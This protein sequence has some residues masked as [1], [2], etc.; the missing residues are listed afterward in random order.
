MVWGC[1]VEGG[2]AAGGGGYR[3]GGGRGWQGGGGAGF[4]GGRARQDGW[5]AGLGPGERAARQTRYAARFAELSVEEQ[6]RFKTVAAHRASAA[7]M[8]PAARHQRWIY[9]M[10]PE[11]LAEVAM[12]RAV[13]FAALPQPLQV[14]YARAWEAYRR[15]FDV[16]RGSWQISARGTA[17]IHL[18]P[19]AVD[20]RVLTR[21]VSTVS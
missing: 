15:D 1:G 12:E 3:R 17:P 9:A 10:D 6:Y 5:W 2:V 4:K 21:Q 13:R 16:P 11:E 8:A 19:E 7:G 20:P 18:L 14:A